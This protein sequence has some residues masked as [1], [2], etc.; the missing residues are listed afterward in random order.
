MGQ[1]EVPSQILID[2]LVMADPSILM[3]GGAEGKA[4]NRPSRMN[5]SSLKGFVCIKKMNGC[6]ERFDDR[7]MSVIQP[8]Q[9][10]EDVEYWG[11]HVLI[12]KFFGS[13]TFSSCVGIV[14]ASDMEP[15]RGYGNSSSSQQLFYGYFLK[16]V[17][18]KQGF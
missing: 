6:L 1:F 13:L 18:L 3:R 9:I 11:K 12:C 15:E 4:K 14:G 5:A 7:S 16:Y 10:S 2:D 8:D 17:R